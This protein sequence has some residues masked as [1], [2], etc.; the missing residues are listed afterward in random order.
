MLLEACEEEKDTVLDGIASVQDRHLGPGG[1]NKAARDFLS[2]HWGKRRLTLVSGKAL[3]SKLSGWAQE[4]YQTSIGA[5]A[6]ARAFRPNEIP[7][8]MQEVIRAIEDGSPFP[9]TP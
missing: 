3:L 7:R 9:E 1:S 5:M 4:K 2:Q 8:E 6:I